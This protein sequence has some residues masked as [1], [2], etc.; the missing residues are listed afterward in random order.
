MMKLQRAHRYLFFFYLHNL[1]RFGYGCSARNHVSKL[2]CRV[3][4]LRLLQGRCVVLL[5][6]PVDRVPVFTSPYLAVASL[7]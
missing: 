7:E 2:H 3:A 5:H 6:L 4:Y 1:A